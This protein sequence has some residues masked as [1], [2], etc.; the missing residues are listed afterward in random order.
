MESNTKYLV[1]ASAANE[2]SSASLEVMQVVLAGSFAFDILD[3]I[4]GGTLNTD[5]PE[6]VMDSIYK[7]LVKPPLVWFAVNMAW[8]F[9]LIICLLKLMRRLQ[10]QA[11][12]QLTLRCKVN[13]KIDCSAI[14]EWLSSKIVE[15][16]DAS[17]DATTALRKY[18]WKEWDKNKWRGAP[19][20]IEILVDERYNFL[21]SITFTVCL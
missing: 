10:A 2:R 18:Q 14:S 5:A 1:D 8:L 7:Y 15:A 9:L 16:T 11:A 6:W 21:L 17:S 13:K 20:K 12:G 4:S 19:P 3:R